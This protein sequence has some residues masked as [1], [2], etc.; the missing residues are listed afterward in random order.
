MLVIG[1]INSSILVVDPE[2]PENITPMDV[3]LDRDKDNWLSDADWEIEAKR[4]LPE[5]DWDIDFKIQKMSSY[6]V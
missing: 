2:R 6:R 3:I 4:N 1:Y 5:M